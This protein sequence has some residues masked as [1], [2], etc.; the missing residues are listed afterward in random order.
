MATIERNI[1]SAK[2]FLDLSYASYEVKDYDTA[3]ALTAK[4]YANVRFVL[5]ELLVLNCQA[6]VDSHSCE[7]DSL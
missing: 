1:Y 2:Q 7:V 6:H 4:A 5:T 3:L